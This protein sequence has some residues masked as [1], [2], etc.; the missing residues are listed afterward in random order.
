[1]ANSTRTRQV[2]HLSLS[3]TERRTQAYDG[4]NPGEKSVSSLAMCNL[5]L[6]AFETQFL[7]LHNQVKLPFRVHCGNDW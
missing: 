4:A 2:P 5:K 3:R 1:M 7:H 6:L